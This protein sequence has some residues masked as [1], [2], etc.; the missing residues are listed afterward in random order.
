MR[1]LGKGPRALLGAGAGLVWFV[2]VSV[3]S[4]AQHEATATMSSTVVPVALVALISVMCASGFSFLG[5]AWGWGVTAAL[6]GCMLLG[7]IEGPIP[8][9][10]AGLAFSIPTTFSVGLGSLAVWVAFAVSLTLTVTAKTSRNHV[11]DRD[12]SREAV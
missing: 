11:E 4:V 3:A 1:R 6:G 10:Q 9:E 8:S 7:L 2:V 12:Y 5:A